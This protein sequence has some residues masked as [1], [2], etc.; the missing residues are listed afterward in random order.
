MVTA[1]LASLLSHFGWALADLLNA[2]VSRRNSGLTVAFCS[3]P[4][5]LILLIPGWW[6]FTPTT[7]EISIPLVGL[8]LVLSV[9]MNF[10]WLA[11]LLAFETGN[12]PVVGQ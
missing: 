10:S 4:L 2:I 5:S 6:Y 8:A 7:L 12:A 11:F 3:S 1:I 9:L